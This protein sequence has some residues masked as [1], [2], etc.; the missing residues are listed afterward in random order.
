V[1]HLSDFPEIANVLQGKSFQAR[2]RSFSVSNNQYVAIQVLFKEKALDDLL[3][4]LTED[5]RFKKVYNRSDFELPLG[6]K[7]G[8]LFSEGYGDRI[9]IGFEYM[10]DNPTLQSKLVAFD[11]AEKELPIIQTDADGVCVSFQGGIPTQDSGGGTWIVQAFNNNN[12]NFTL[13]PPTYVPPTPTPPASGTNVPV[14]PYNPSMFTVSQ[15]VKDPIRNQAV[16]LIRSVYQDDGR[17]WVIYRLPIGAPNTSTALVSDYYYP[18]PYGTF[19]MDEIY[20]DDLFFYTVD[21]IVRLSD[22]GPW[23]LFPYKWD[24]VSSNLTISSSDVE[25]PVVRIE[26]SQVFHFTVD[27][28]WFYVFDTEKLRVTRARTWW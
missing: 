16:L 3:I 4:L 14:F 22:K 5:L 13:L 7:F 1:I 25:G 28:R 19:K 9:L 20:R 24:Y 2:L 23:S 18:T 27:G 6:Y 12:I 17:G 8:T 21:G 15:Y 10:G 11:P 26:K